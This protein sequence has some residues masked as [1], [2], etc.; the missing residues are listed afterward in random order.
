[1]IFMKGGSTIKLMRAIN[2][3]KPLPKLL[4]ADM[5]CVHVCIAA[6]MSIFPLLFMTNL[7]APNMH[8]KKKKKSRQ[9]LFCAVY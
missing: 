1:M 9:Q 6:C 8:S 2:G 4:E 5:I 3:L 7:I